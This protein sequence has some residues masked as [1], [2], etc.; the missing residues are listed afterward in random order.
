[1]QVRSLAGGGSLIQYDRYLNKK[2]KFE[3]RHTG[4]APCEDEGRDE[5]DASISQGTPK[6][7][8]TPTEARGEARNRFSLTALRGTNLDNTVVR[9]LASRTV[10]RCISVV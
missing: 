1:M 3:H 10:R 5:D 7:A 9:L 4:R 2:G 6:I 8:S